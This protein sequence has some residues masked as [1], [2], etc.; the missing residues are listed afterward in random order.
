VGPRI[1]KDM[2]LIR[3]LAPLLLFASLAAADDTAKTTAPPPK[4]PRIKALNR[5]FAGRIIK[6]KK[7]RVTIYYDFEN[8]EQL[9]D[10]EGVRPPNLL[11]ASDNRFSIRGGRLVLEGSTSIR[12][13]MEGRGELRARFWVRCGRQANIGTVF[14]EP[15]MSQYYVVLN[16]FDERFYKN[17]ALILAACGL[18]EDEGAQDASTGLVN[19]RDIFRGNVKKKAKVGEDVMV[20]VSKNGFKES[21]RVADVEGKGS[22]KG[23]TKKMDTYQ[24]GLWVHHSR[25]TFDDLTIEIELTDEFLNLNDLKAEVVEDWEE[26]PTTGPLAGVRGV[27]PRIRSEIDAYALGKGEARLVVKTVGRTG[28]PK[29]VREIAAQLL[30]DRN[31]SKVVPIVIDLLYSTDKQTRTLGIGIVK[32]IVGNNF[33]YSPGSSE[34]KRSKSIQKLNQHLVQ[35]RRKYFG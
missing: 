17:G 24:F 6:I 3:F 26:V 20:E 25:A 22:S 19:W 1:E 2:H 15:V 30:K 34:K 21:C 13:K 16:L 11:D 5:V 29:K 18:N 14:T 27:P 35:N 28:I 8:A 10:F 23:K 31:D 7:K 12:H 9:K 33:G 4:K 32:S